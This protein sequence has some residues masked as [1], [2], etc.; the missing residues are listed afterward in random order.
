VCTAE[1]DY[2]PTLFFTSLGCEI[3]H[4][5]LYMLLLPLVLLLVVL[6]EHSL[7]LHFV[8]KPNTRRCFLEEIPT[9]TLVLIKYNNLDYQQHWKVSDDQQ[10]DA[11][12]VN[13]QVFEPMNNEPVQSAWAAKDGKWAFTARVGGEHK[14]CV[15]SQG[16]GGPEVVRFQLHVEVGEAAVDYAEVAK[17]EHLSAIEVEMRKLAG[18]VRAIRAEQVYQREREELFRNTSESTNARVMW[19][20]LAQTLVLIVSGAYQVQ[21]LKK[22]FQKKKLV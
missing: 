2:R 3:F 18:K 15:E 10:P 7:A 16:W 19:W 17:V 9:E 13:V 21:H 14:L 8:L 6:V 22:F 4:R 5:L 20:S 1:E 12:G 11:F